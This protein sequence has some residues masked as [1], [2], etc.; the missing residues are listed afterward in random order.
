MPPKTR[1]GIAVPFETEP[2]I[3]AQP[4]EP[5][6]EAP[7]APLFTLEDVQRLIQE[8]LAKQ[9]AVTSPVVEDDNRQA[10]GTYP[11]T[12]Y[13]PRI[14]NERFYV[15]GSPYPQHFVNGMFTCNNPNDEA[16]VRKALAAHGR[17]KADRW[18]GNDRRLPWKD[19][20]TGF[21]TLNDNARYD[22]ELYHQD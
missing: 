1:V 21:T 4:E 19:K 8:A 17:D 13:N 14:M 6:V 9:A 15:I 2:V 7:E 3:P 12:Y 10:E 18:R 16:S 22:F 20:A 5:E 11:V